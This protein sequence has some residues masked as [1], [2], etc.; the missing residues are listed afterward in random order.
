[1]RLEVYTELH[2]LEKTSQT[3]RVNFVSKVGVLSVMSA[4]KTGFDGEN[5][6]MSLFS[7]S[8]G[9]AYTSILDT[10]AAPRRLLHDGCS[11]TAEANGQYIA[12]RYFWCI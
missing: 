7:I 12:C 3:L 11:T 9:Y 1:M 10:T 8:M 5:R 2:L 4:I 6:V